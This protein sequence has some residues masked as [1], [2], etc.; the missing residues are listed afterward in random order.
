MMKIQVGMDETVAAE[1][2]KLEQ[3]KE[4]NVTYGSYDLVVK[5]NFKTIEDF[6]KFLFEKIR[7]IEGITETSSMIV[8]K[9]IV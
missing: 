7:R 2:Q 3:I 9:Q 1:I 6:D 4:A 8:A 5:V